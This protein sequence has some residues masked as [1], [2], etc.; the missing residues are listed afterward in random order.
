MGG[1][2]GEQ[3]PE[4]PDKASKVTLGSVLLFI[5]CVILYPVGLLLFF[6]MAPIVVGIIELYGFYQDWK[7]R[8]R[9]GD[10]DA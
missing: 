1:R 2:L 10:K 6:V 3:I 9:R 7:Y 5:L 8:A 4:L